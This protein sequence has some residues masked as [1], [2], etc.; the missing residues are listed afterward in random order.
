MTEQT[1]GASTA[2][3]EP[4]TTLSIT[5]NPILKSTLAKREHLQP[6]AGLLSVLLRWNKKGMVKMQVKGVTNN[7]L[8]TLNQNLFQNV[9]CLQQKIWKAQEREVF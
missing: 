5:A 7:W 1:N 8:P 9:I 4:S 3:T 2:R 6:A